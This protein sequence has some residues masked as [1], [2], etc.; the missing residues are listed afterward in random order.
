MGWFKTPLGR[1]LC[2][3]CWVIGALLIAHT[4]VRG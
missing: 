2:G 4:V 1:A 3:A